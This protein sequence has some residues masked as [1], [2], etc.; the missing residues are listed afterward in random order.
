MRRR[1]TRSEAGLSLLELLAVL[2]IVAVLVQAAAPAF[3]R[4]LADIRIS[5]Q[6]NHLRQTLQL[7]RQLAWTTGK[8]LVLCRSRSGLRCEHSGGWQDG[9]IL[10]RN[11]DR[12]SPPQ[13]D[14]GEAVEL[15]AAAT[16]GIN[17]SANRTAFV[18]RPAAKRSTNGTFRA[19]ALG[20]N[21]TG[22]ALIVSY[23]GKT[24]EQAGKC[25][26]RDRS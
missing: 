9:W 7:G 5:I 18:L 12:D 10:F 23:T 26:T 8:D 22:R 25:D 1:F 14:P 6:V 16:H 17:I 13:L 20:R 24:R 2:S 4:L 19:C 15:R 11:D 21:G 3:S